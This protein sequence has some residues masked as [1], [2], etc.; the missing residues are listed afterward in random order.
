MSSV[1]TDRWGG[2]MPCA[3]PGQVVATALAARINSNIGKRAKQ[4]TQLRKTLQHYERQ[5]QQQRPSSSVVARGLTGGD[6]RGLQ[7]LLT[8]PTAAAMAGA[9]GNFPLGGPGHIWCS[10]AMCPVGWVVAPAG[11]Q[12]TA[13][14]SDGRIPCGTTRATRNGILHAR[15]IHAPWPWRCPGAGWHPG[16][17]SLLSGS[18]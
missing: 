8:L 16:D 9:A 5:Q 1:F 12:R 11:H 18:L 13:P 3:D 10:A 15:A 7:T 17:S 14:Q 2:A 6:D 4:Q